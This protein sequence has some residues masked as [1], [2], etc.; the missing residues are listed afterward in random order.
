QVVN[1]PT[2]DGQVGVETYRVSAQ[3]V[4]ARYGVSASFTQAN[5][6]SNPVWQG[7]VSSMGALPD[8]VTFT[9]PI[10]ATWKGLLYVPIPGEVRA[11]LEGAAKAEVWLPGQA[12]PR[13]PAVLDMG[14][15]PF[16]AQ[17]ELD[18][19]ARLQLLL[20]VNTVPL[21]PVNRMHLWPQSPEG[22]LAVTLGGDGY[23]HRIDPFVGSALL[24]PISNYSDILQPGSLDLNEVFSI[25]NG[26][27][28]F[29]ALP[30]ER[31]AIRWE[32]ELYADGGQYQMNVHTGEDWQVRLAL[33]GLP[34]INE[35][36]VAGGDHMVQVTLSQGWHHVQLDVMGGTSNR[37]V[38]WLWTRPDGLR[39]VIPPY[40]FRYTPS[41]GPGTSFAWPAKPEP[42]NCP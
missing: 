3:Q 23:P 28:L 34:I 20:Q 29:G 32:G 4:Q 19:P 36:A 5:A 12:N 13:G 33:N 9:Y 14:W 40:H 27:G 30:M 17:A 25:F 1:L 39:E 11:Q 7:Q 2:S 10:T 42:I 15:V 31:G 26:P 18:N 41:A 21:T 24:W 22:G 6:Q 37:G 35:C 38:Q 8:G 16:V